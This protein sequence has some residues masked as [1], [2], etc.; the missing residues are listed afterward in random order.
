MDIMKEHMKSEDGNIM[1]GKLVKKTQMQIF[2][3]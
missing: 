1:I 3:F 2:K